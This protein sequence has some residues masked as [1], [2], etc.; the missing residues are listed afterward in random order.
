[1][2]GIATRP[3]AG[4]SMKPDK[5]KSPGSGT[6]LLFGV[7]MLA[8]GGALMI[9]APALPVSHAAMRYVRPSVE[10]VSHTEAR[11]YGACSI[12]VGLAVIGFSLPRAGK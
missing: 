3:I 12:I 4:I 8:L 9:F 5:R 2:F 1:M 7:A 10:H 6:G 11:F